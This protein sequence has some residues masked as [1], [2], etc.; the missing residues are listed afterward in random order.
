[1]NAKNVLVTG[2]TGFVGANLVEQLLQDGHNVHLFVRDGYKDWRIQNFLPHLRIHPVNLLDPEP[3]RAEI[4]AI[5]P[6]WVFHLATYGAYS[7]QEDLNQA[8]QTNLLGTIHLVEACRSVG[9]EI[10]VNTGSSSEYGA[11]TQATSEDD[12]LE[13]N[14]YYAVAKASATM[15]CRYTAQ[16]FKLPIFTLRLY[17]VFGPYEE[18][19]RLIPT[20]I[21]KGFQGQFPPLA[22][23]EIARDFIFTE[24]VT[25]AYLSVADLGVGLPPGEIYNVGSGQQTTLKDVV[26]ITREIF[27][28]PDDPHWGS[29]ENRSWDTQRWMSNNDRLRATGWQPAFDFRAGYLK[30]TEWFRQNPDLLRKIY[31]QS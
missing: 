30:T 6:D 25:C 14:S 22:H 19:G 16:R 24:D 3:L 11:K 26:E 17:S 29:M 21:V 28:I 5:R 27:E 1:M 10:F 20:L 12:F 31:S 4:A 15:F 9:F 23:P 7:W 18:P 2:G 13:P 8:I